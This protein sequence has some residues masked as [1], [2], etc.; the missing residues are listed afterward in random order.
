MERCELY[1]VND[2]KS[3]L[4][5]EV[6]NLLK[7]R[8]KKIMDIYMNDQMN[9]KNNLETILQGLVLGNQE[10][11]IVISYARSSYITQSSLF[12]IS[13]YVKEPFLEEEPDCFYY[14]MGPFFEGMEDDWLALNHKLE[15]KF[16]RIF[17]SEKEEVRRWY[18]GQIYIN[19]SHVFRAVID[20]M[21]AEKNK[22]IFYGGYMEDLELIGRI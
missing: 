15:E 10:G 17:S 3:Y 5:P 6:E 11:C 22:D 18:M 19:C 1:R 13:Y 21:K 14:D 9:I 4:Q 7:A 8:D 16:V 20:D 12:L 2:M